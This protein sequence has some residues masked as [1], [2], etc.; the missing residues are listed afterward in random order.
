VLLALVLVNAVLYVAALTVTGLPLA[1]GRVPT[2]VVKVFVLGSALVMMFNLLVM[3]YLGYEWATEKR[4][5]P[6]F[7][8]AAVIC[9]LSALS[10]S[11]RGEKAS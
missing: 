3:L 10:G 5:A 9:G 6:P 1:E 2:S 8:V 7:V 11:S 4:G